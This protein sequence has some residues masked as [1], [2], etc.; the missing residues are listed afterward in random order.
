MRQP[1]SLTWTDDG[2]IVDVNASDAVV[3]VLTR[4]VVQSA[5][6]DPG[7]EADVET[8]RL[9][10]LSPDICNALEGMVKHFYAHWR[11]AHDAAPPE[12]LDAVALLKRVKEGEPEDTPAPAL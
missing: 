5:D 3:A 8:A 2:K 4:S 10:A 12:I 6:N 1:G 9:F 7:C 11:Y